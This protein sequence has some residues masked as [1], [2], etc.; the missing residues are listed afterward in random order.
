MNR[1]GKGKGKRGREAASRAV[2]T[3]L[4]QRPREREGQRLRSGDRIQGRCVFGFTPCAPS[5]RPS[6][7]PVPARGR[8]AGT[9][10]GSEL[11]IA[12]SPRPRAARTREPDASPRSLSAGWS[13]RPRDPAG[14][15]ARMRSATASGGVGR[16]GDRGPLDCP[17]L[18]RIK[19]LGRTGSTPP[20]LPP[21]RRAAPT[22]SARAVQAASRTSARPGSIATLR[23]APSALLCECEPPRPCFAGAAAA[24]AVAVSGGPCDRA[25]PGALSRC[26]RGN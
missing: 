25:A 19:D 23:W 10:L 21:F 26:C 20:P 5:A 7:S 13:V 4:P 24:A 12:S 1:G 14:P 8:E 9:E 17:R 18:L 6:P 15:E 2:P 11:R 22:S 16:G 3:P